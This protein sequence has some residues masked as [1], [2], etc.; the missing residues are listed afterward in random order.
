[1]LWIKISKCLRCNYHI[2][3]YKFRMKKILEFKLNN[4][5]ILVHKNHFTKLIFF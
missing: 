5:L 2:Y 3:T 4:R 1:M